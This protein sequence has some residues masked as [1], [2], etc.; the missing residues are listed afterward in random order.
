MKT[1]KYKKAQLSQV[2][3]Y[4]LTLVVMITV[5]FFGYKAISGVIQKGERVA[6]VSF[7]TDLE[8]AVR[9]ISGDYGSVRAYDSKNPL[10]VPAGYDSVCFIDFDR[11]PPAG[12]SSISG[13]NPIICDAWETYGGNS[14]GKG[15]EAADANV[16]LNPPGIIDVK[17]YKIEVDTNLNR[18][19]DAKDG[20][21]FCLNVV[22]GRLDIRLEGKGDHAFITASSTNSYTGEI[23]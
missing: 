13:L 9:S 3:V 16:F 23:P 20:G 22:S 8:G 14:E 11:S 12:C 6:F 2:F 21:Y 19:E 15:W 10:R 1:K 17:V 18:N 7:K 4:I 5:L